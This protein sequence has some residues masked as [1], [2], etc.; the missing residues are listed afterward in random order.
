MQNPLPTPD[1]INAMASKMATGDHQAA[2]EVL[3][4]LEHMLGL[5]A[6]PN[7]PQP[8]AVQPGAVQPAVPADPSGVISERRAPPTR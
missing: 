2:E 8:G 1:Q 5:T 3:T 7:A 6:L 4:T